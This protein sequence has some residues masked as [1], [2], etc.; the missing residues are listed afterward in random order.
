MHCLR[1]SVYACALLLSFTSGCSL[2]NPQET[3]TFAD[4]EINVRF[5]ET[6]GN[7][8]LSPSF[9]LAN[10]NRLAKAQALDRFV[11][12]VFS[13]TPQLEE[14]GQELVRREIFV[15]ENRRLSAALRVPLRSAEEDY[16]IAEVQAF[17][18]LD[19]IYSGSDVFQFDATTQTATVEVFLQPVAFFASFI[20]QPNL[21]RFVLGQASAL[22]TTITAFDFEGNGI[23]VTVPL[24]RANQANNAILLWGDTTLV[25]ARARQGTVFRG[26]V[27]SRLSYTGAAAS[28]LIACTWNQPVNF[29][30]EIRNPLNQTISETLPGDVPNGS[31]VILLTSAGYGPEVFEWRV[32]RITAGQFIVNV[33]RQNANAVGSGTVYVIRREGL[34]EQ[35]VETIPFEFRLIDTENTKPVFSF[36]WP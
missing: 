9:R 31:G 15:G 28:V 3:E 12:T 22:D 17:Q 6:A 19:L 21:P 20:P 26:E 8:T 14:I 32:G 33:V 18:R 11:I 24:G 36:N 29:N 30:L 1:T 25:K 7:E 2:F 35:T 16:F 34:A 5:S 27:T 10:E 23:A 4:L 13:Y